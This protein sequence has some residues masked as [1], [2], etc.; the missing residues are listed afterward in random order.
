MGQGFYTPIGSERTLESYLAH[1]PKVSPCSL[2]FLFNV[3][4]P[5]CPIS[6]SPPCLFFIFSS[7]PPLITPLPLFLSLF[8]LQQARSSS[9]HFAGCDDSFSSLRFPLSSGL[10]VPPQRCSPETP[11]ARSSFG[12]HLCNFLQ[13][14]KGEPAREAPGGEAAHSTCCQQPFWRSE[15][16]GLP[17]HLPTGSCH[18]HHEVKA[19]AWGTDV[20][21]KPPFPINRTQRMNKHS[22][23]KT[24]VRGIARH[25]A[26]TMLTAGHRKSR[27]A[28]HYISHLSASHH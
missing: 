21:C 7:Y 16:R 17:L 9:S 12:F 5:S 27:P 19:S 11:T 26:S 8:T 28:R 24:K 20:P 13:E 23:E 14:R 22:K 4:V 15:P 2:S 3:S 10:A 6:I 25:S 18:Q 1:F